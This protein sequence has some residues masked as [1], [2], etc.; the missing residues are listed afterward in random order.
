MIRLFKRKINPS[1]SEETLRET[2]PREDKLYVL[3]EDGINKNKPNVS[4][5]QWL[6]R[7]Q[8]IWVD[9]GPRDE[10]DLVDILIAGASIITLRR[11]YW[12]KLDLDELREL[13][14]N[15][16]YLYFEKEEGYTTSIHPLSNGVVVFTPMEEI[17]RDF[18]LEGKLKEI[19]RKT[20]VYAHERNPMYVR[21]WENIG[22]KGLIVNI[23][24]IKRFKGV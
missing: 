18:T 12:W 21:S 2:Q 6:S 14:E 11:R 16:L 5:Y 13:T 9:A 10:G 24:D 23:E 19:S 3:D 15:P 4:I 20:E 17:R 8:E 7:Y 22:V 1:I